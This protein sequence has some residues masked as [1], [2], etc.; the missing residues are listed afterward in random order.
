MESAWKQPAPAV[1]PPEKKLRATAPSG[2]SADA[3]DG[4]THR[5]YRLPL[6]PC[7]SGKA[8]MAAFE[9][10]Q[11]RRRKYAK[12]QAERRK[13]ELAMEKS[14]EQAVKSKEQSKLAPNILEKVSKA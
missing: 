2:V 4:C 7:R 11:E 10:L 12:L 3:P 13:A 14:I 5:K 9:A 1:Y 8:G 6:L